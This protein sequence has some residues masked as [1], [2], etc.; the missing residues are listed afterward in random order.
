[1]GSP[2][3]AVCGA[4]I[5]GL[6]GG[7][8]GGSIGLTLGEFVDD[9]ILDNHQCLDCGHRFSTKSNSATAY[10]SSHALPENIYDHE[11]DEL[12]QH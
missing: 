6:I 11:D 9:N 12:D 4:V 1:M 7:A 2:I 5:T 3:G 8:T 10:D